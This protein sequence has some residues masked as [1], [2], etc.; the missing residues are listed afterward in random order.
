MVRQRAYYENT[1]ILAKYPLYAEKYGIGLVAK[2]DRECGPMRVEK[3]MA[4]IH[5]EESEKKTPL[6]RKGIGAIIEKYRKT[7]RTE[8]V[9]TDWKSMYER[10]KAAHD[11]TKVSLGVA[12]KTMAELCILIEKLK[13]KDNRSA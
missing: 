4:S 12:I 9:S 7:D 10:E 5:K 1:R 11:A 2:M 8:R 6:T 13:M 3:V